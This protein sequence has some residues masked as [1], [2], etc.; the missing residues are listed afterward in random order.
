ML[1][2][3]YHLDLPK[4]MYSHIRFMGFDKNAAE[5]DEYSTRCVDL[6][7]RLEVSQVVLCTLILDVVP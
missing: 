6:W 7:A 5:G 1:F 3:L 4:C 2:P